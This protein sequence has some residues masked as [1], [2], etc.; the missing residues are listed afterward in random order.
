M[1][2]CDGILWCT[3][4][5]YNILW[6]TVMVYY[7]KVWYT[8]V[9]CDILWYAVIFCGMLWYTVVYCD[10]IYYNGKIFTSAHECLSNCTAILLKYKMQADVIGLAQTRKQFRP[11]PS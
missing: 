11:F 4:I 6:Y 9:C 8:G 2:Y 7:K 3:V 5:Y 1:V 10:M